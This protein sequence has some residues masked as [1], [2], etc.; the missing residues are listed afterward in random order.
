MGIWYSVFW[1]VRYL[2]WHYRTCTWLQVLHYQNIDQ[3]FIAHIK[4][5][6]TWPS[7]A[8]FLS[9]YSKSQPQIIWFFPTKCSLTVTKV[10]SSLQPTATKLKI[11]PKSP[12]SL[13][14]KSSPVLQVRPFYSHQMKMDNFLP[15]VKG[16]RYYLSLQNLHTGYFWYINI[17]IN[18]P[19]KTLLQ[20]E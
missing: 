19:Y 15:S 4:K 1:V 17:Y 8:P 13:G 6:K 20:M 18:M 2:G 3:Q 16:N 5:F 14:G 11:L 9:R 10:S 12:L 7:K